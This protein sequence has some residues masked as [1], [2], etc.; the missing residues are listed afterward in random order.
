MTLRMLNDTA[1]GRLLRQGDSKGNKSVG[2]VSKTHAQ[3]TNGDLRMVGVT[4][5]SSS[6]S[7]QSYAVK[8]TAQRA[9]HKRRARTKS[10]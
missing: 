10:S 7:G 8:G 1:H 9:G 2:D 4:Q 5:Q 6:M 3:R